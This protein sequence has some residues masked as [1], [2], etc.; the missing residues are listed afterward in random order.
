MRRYRCG[1]LSEDE[2]RQG[3]NGETYAGVLHTLSSE[4][5]GSEE[6]TLPFIERHLHGYTNLD[7]E[8]AAPVSDRC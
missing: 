5:E 6:C 2:D 3:G 8:I 1:N 4:A 7:R